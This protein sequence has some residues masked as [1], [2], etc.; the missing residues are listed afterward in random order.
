MMQNVFSIET[1]PGEMT[2]LFLPG[3]VIKT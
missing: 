1:D 2:S 3:H